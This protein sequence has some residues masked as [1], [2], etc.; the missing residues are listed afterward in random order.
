MTARINESKTL[1][2]HILCGCKCKFNGKIV[3]QINCGIMI[4]VDRIVKNVMYVKKIVWNPVTCNCEN[5]KY[6]VSIMDGS[7]IM[8]DEI[9]ELCE[10]ET[11]FYEKKAKCKMQFL[12]FGCS[13]INYYSI[14]DSC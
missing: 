11:N 3:I 7:A 5:G 8:C 2:K 14:I 1:T 10:E 6:L 4:N 13:F 12:Y 9:I